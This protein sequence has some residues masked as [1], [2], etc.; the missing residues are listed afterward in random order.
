M[1]RVAEVVRLGERIRSMREKLD[2]SLLE[3]SDKTEIPK[4]SLMELEHGFFDTTRNILKDVKEIA[5]AFG[6]SEILLS[7]GYGGRTKNED[8]AEVNVVVNKGLK[9]F[10]ID[11]KSYYAINFKNA[12]KKSKK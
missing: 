11:G 1:K 8:V 10:I 4:I 9:E 7:A 3:L 6:I 2:M 5:K 12:L